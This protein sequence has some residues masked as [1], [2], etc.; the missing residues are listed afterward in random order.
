[1]KFFIGRIE[2]LEWSRGDPEEIGPHRYGSGQVKEVAEPLGV[3]LL[4]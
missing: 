1:M 3:L 2:F 4:R